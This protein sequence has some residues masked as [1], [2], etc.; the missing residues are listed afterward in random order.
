[1]SSSTVVSV[2]SL[3]A[4]CQVAP[5]T[6]LSSTLASSPDTR[7][8]PPAL[9]Q[10]HVD[11]VVLEVVLDLLELLAAGAEDLA[12]LVAVVLEPQHREVAHHLDVVGDVGVQRIAEPGIP[13]G[14]HDQPLGKLLD[15]GGEHRLLRTHF[16][17]PFHRLRHDSSSLSFFRRI[18]TILSRTARQYRKRQTRRVCE[19]LR[20]VLTTPGGETLKLSATSRSAAMR[21]SSRPVALASAQPLAAPS[22]TTPPT[23]AAGSTITIQ[24]AGS[25]NPRDF[26]TVVPK[27]AP[28]GSYRGVLCMLDGAAT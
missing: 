8:L 20:K 25:G 23:A 15:A 13:F 28:E 11:R 1:M 4:L 26:V 3:T 14:E 27:G 2:A 22:L 18:G 9:M 6:F 7:S 21:S 10:Q 17:N 19:T 24:A 5:S 16:R 12:R